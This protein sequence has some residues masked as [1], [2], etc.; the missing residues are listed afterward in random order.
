VIFR[1]LYKRRLRAA[2]GQFIEKPKLE[3]L[4]DGISEWQALKLL[5]PARWLCSGEEKIAA[6]S[7][8]A[9]L[10]TRHAREPGAPSD[11]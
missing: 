8:V 7:E 6:L 4:A 2:F 5:P 1:Y 9:R 11:R 3:K 10:S